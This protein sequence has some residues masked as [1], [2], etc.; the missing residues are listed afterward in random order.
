LNNLYKIRDKWCIALNKDTFDGNIKSSQRSESTNKALNVIANKSTSLTKFVVGFEILVMSWHRNEADE[1]YHCYQ[2]FAPRAIKRSVILRHASDVCA[3]KLCKLFEEEY[4]NGCGACDHKETQCGDN[5]YK[6]E[7]MMHGRGLKVRIL[8][9][10]LFTMEVKCSC[11][12]LEWLGIL[13]FHAL[14]TLYIKNVKEIPKQYILS[15]WTKNAKERV[16]SESESSQRN[17]NESK[18][19]FQNRAMRLACDLVT[20]GQGQEEGREVIWST[21]KNRRQHL[22]NVMKNLSLDGHSMVRDNG[23]NENV[24]EF[25]NNKDEAP[26]LDPPFVRPKGISNARLKGHFEKRKKPSQG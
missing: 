14:A 26:V 15:R 12:I 1:D 16:Y 9:L 18:I 19:I 2:S 24:N 13:Y 21:L 3:H 5:L 7:F 8:Y 11:E 10:D 23:S 22:H 4:L 25:M 6:F 17:S 20:T